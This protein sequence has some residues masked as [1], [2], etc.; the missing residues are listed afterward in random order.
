MKGP[1]YIRAVDKLASA[2]PL[3]V[4][5]HEEEGS[6]LH[7]HDFTELVMVQR[8]QARHLVGDAS[9]MITAGDVFV[10]PPSLPHGYEDA[11]DLH[12]VNVLVGREL[13]EKVLFKEL[14]D[15]VG[16]RALFAVEPQVRATG[17]CSPQLH[18]TGDQFKQL[19]IL[20]DQ[21]IAE[22]QYKRPGS[23][24]T[25][26][27][28]LI[29]L[30]SNLARW[31]VRPTAAP[32]RKIMELASVLNYIDGHTDE[33]LH[34]DQLSELAQVSPRTLLRR[35]KESLGMTPKAYVLQARLHRARDLLRESR[36]SITEIAHEVGFCDHSHLTKAFQKQFGL[37]PK[38]YRSQS[39]H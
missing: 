4:T 10:I 23:V 34:L 31:Y 15:L 11:T 22:Q 20:I 19:E 7:C 38:H 24:G 29:V 32:A 28:L 5:R 33:S 37:S 27:A 1:T 16:M 25:A 17:Q 26:R 30:M 14:D 8:G 2:F 35:F 12:I 3:R 9:H 39:L 6:P 21:L 36:N 18:C 13:V